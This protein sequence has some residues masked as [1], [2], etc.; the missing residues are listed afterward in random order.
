MAEKK[1]PQ[2]NTRSITLKIGRDTFSVVSLE[3]A[4]QIYGRLRD[5]SG[6][7]ASTFPEGKLST[8]H[9]ISYNG[10]VWS[11]S[12]CVYSPYENASTQP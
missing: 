9:R 12:T 2:T 10:R 6:E 8:G 5:E 7:G 1:K 4:S 11:G 3:E